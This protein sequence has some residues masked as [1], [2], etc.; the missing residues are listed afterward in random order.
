MNLTNSDYIFLAS[1]LLSVLT[2]LGLIVLKRYRKSTLYRKLRLNSHK[3]YFYGRICLAI[4]TFCL[5]LFSASQF[6]QASDSLGLLIWSFIAITSLQFFWW[7][8]T[9]NSQEDPFS[10]L[11]L[12]NSKN[13]INKA[14][15]T[16][17]KKHNKEKEIMQLPNIGQPGSTLSM[18]I[19][20]TFLL[21]N[22]IVG[23][24]FIVW[25]VSLGDVQE[26]LKES[27]GSLS[28]IVFLLLV[29]IGYLLGAILRLMKCEIPDNL[30]GFYLT[31]IERRNIP[32]EKFPYIEWL[33][34]RCSREYPE[35]VTFYKD[36]WGK[37][38]KKRENSFFNFCKVLLISKAPNLANECYAAEAL[39]RYLSSMF[40]GISLSFLII[41][42]VLIKQIFSPNEELS[43]TLLLIELIYG[44]SALL[45]IRNYRSIRM[46]EVETVFAASFAVRHEWA[47]L[48]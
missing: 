27:G 11:Y 6:F 21:F 47:Y 18:L 28:V 36:T 32:K 25:T 37:H 15:L 3:N 31:H 5:T 41:F 45:I 44:G 14:A 48:D 2:F 13:G 22:I 20:G 26:F 43:L 10:P 30:S 38:S 46:K 17:V 9:Y 4:F 19:P 23:L 16:E 34:R 39:N 1:G 29:C 7:N 33:G 24:Y 12:K 8:L 35:A 42:F 40:Y